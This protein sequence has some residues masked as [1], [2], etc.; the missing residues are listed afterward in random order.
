[1]KIAIASDG[2]S[3]ESKVSAISGKAPYYLI[4]NETE[5]VKIIKNPFGAGNKAGI[6]ATQM[7]ASEEVELVIGGKFGPIMA[8]SLESQNI[9]YKEISNITVKQALIN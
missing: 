8:S 6:K 3:E 7:L 2:E 4:F 9:K 1:M 5:L